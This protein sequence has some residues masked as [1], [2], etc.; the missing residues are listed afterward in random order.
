MRHPAGSGAS[1]SRAAPA[2][3][4]PTAPEPRPIVW[5][6]QGVGASD[7]GMNAWWHHP[8]RTL[9]LVTD[10]EYRHLP[11]Q[12]TSRQHL[13]LALQGKRQK[14]VGTICG[15]VGDFDKAPAEGTQSTGL[16]ACPIGMKPRLC[17]AA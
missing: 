16:R 6:Q 1:S 14:L 11:R 2:R 17:S 12:A 7:D 9:E 3:R 10:A 4:P 5:T 15:R 8:D 13:E